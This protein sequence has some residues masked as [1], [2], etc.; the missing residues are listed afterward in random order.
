MCTP[1]WWHAS[2]TGRIARTPARWPATRGRCRCLAQRPFPSMMMP[3]CLGRSVRAG[4]GTAAGAGGGWSVGLGVRTDS[5]G[6]PFRDR[7]GSDLEDLG[8]LSLSGVVD[9]GDELVGDLLHLGE[10]G[11]DLVLADVAVLLHAAQ[12]V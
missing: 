3:I 4:S 7:R 11:G 9:A 5:G 8:L 12:V 2:I 1:A 6:Q 10:L